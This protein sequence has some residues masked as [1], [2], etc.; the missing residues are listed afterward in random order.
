MI[1]NV[2]TYIINIQVVINR[3]MLIEK[4]STLFLILSAMIRNIFKVAFRNIRRDRVL[5]IL[6]VTGLATGMACAILLLLWV[7]NEI[8]F[9]RF[10]KNAKNLYRVTST[11]TYAGRFHREAGTPFPLAALLKEEY[12][13]IIRSTRYHNLQFVFKKGEDKING[14]CA[15]IDKDFFEMF[16]IDFI[17]GDK[18]SALT[19][20]YEI[21]ITEDLAYKYFGEEEPLGKQMTRWPNEIFTVTGVIKK[22]PRNSHFYFDCIV[23]NELYSTQYGKVN[24]DSLYGWQGVFN[25]TFVELLEETDSK[26]VEGKIRDIVQKKRDGSNTELFLQKIRDIHLNSRKYEGDIAYGNIE[27]VKLAGLLAI[28][29]LTVACINFTNLLIAQ[30]SGRAKEIGIRKM[31]GASRQK[32]I[33]HFLGETFLIAFIAN[34]IAM[35]LFE[36]ML[37][38]FNNLLG[39]KLEINYLSTGLYACLFVVVI[40]CTLLGGSYP[41]L[42]LSS[43]K[44]VTTIRGMV[45]EKP[46]KARLRKILIVSQF[47]LSFLFIIS[48]MIVRKQLDY[49]F[50]IDLGQNISN[51]GYF[52]IPEGMDH[53][54]LKSELDND[55]DILNTTIAYTQ[56]QSIINHQLNLGV[57]KDGDTVFLNGLMADKDYAATFQLEIKEGR[58]LSDDEYVGKE[59]GPINVVINEKAK[60]L[61]GIKDIGEEL[62]SISG[63]R[64]TII[65]LVKD[66]H[67]R[68]LHSFIEPLI[69]LPVASELK[70]RCY[71]RINP[72][73][74]NSAVL[75]VG[76]KLK[77]LNQNY[78]INIKFLEDDFNNMYFVE[79]VASVVLG[80]MTFLAIVISCL[81]LIGLSVFMITR[82]TKEIGIRKTNGAKPGEIF[83][84]LSKEYV[85]LVLISFIIACPI[86]WYATN[87]WLQGYAYRTKVSPLIF[88]ISLIIVT[89]ITILTIGYQSY[90]AARKNPVEAL[91]YE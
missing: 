87:I 22:L 44:T 50:Y 69:I 46:G 13:E 51:V 34:I 61:L 47:T 33:L 85:K 40:F 31:A 71:I 90:K 91:R 79:R 37:P 86:A 83:K 68:T 54:T 59:S 39:V 52:E 53:R 64:L 32:I 78:I 58:F 70:G 60:A 16:D 81:G 38:G 82:R 9:D 2:N 28:L 21:L 63:R 1:W 14:N 24:A 6:N 84:M 76:N 56:A 18:S 30:S 42:Y 15:L 55:P 72:D 45:D 41:A 89:L 35:I 12:P 3:G 5:S 7:R 36:L 74:T 66:F 4:I 23:S 65:G 17:N 67:Y 26:L 20:P 77:N 29:I 62:I 43:L 80:F 19:R 57:R 48:T 8:S 75:S 88:I 10:H 49:I 27:Q 11:S 73:H 25:Y